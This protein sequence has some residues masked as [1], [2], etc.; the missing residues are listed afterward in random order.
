MGRWD[1]SNDSNLSF[2]ALFRVLRYESGLT[3]QQVADAVG[4]SKPTVW[5]WE[6]GRAKPGRE[7]LHA[8]A[9]A[10]G[11]VPEVLSSAARKR[12][13]TKAEPKDLEAKGH[14]RDALIAEG[15]AMI[16]KAYGTTPSAVRVFIEV[17]AGQA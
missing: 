11:V 7:K 6:N 16:A 13:L 1:G 17:E 5:G 10:L 9:E 4:V 8:I 3:M 14:N 12:L 15:R 2:N